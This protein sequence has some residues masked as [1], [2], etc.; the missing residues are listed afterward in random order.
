MATGGRGHTDVQLQEPP[1][2]AKWVYVLAR[3]RWKQPDPN[4]RR[5]KGSTPLAYVREFINDKRTEEIY[6]SEIDKTRRAVLKRGG[7]KLYG[8]YRLLVVFAFDSRHWMRGYLVDQ[9]GRPASPGTIAETMGLDTNDVAWAVRAL[10]GPEIGLLERVDYAAAWKR[11][12]LV[13]LLAERQGPPDQDPPPEGGDGRQA[14]TNDQTDAQAATNQQTRPQSGAGP[15]GD[16]AE[17]GGGVAATTNCNGND[18]ENA[19]AGA[20]NGACLAACGNGNM[21]GNGRNG[22]ERRTGDDNGHGVTADGDAGPERQDGRPPGHPNAAGRGRGPGRRPPAETGPGEAAGPEAKPASPDLPD[23]G[24]QPPAAGPG[25][26]GCGD[27]DRETPAETGPGEAAGSDAELAS[28]AR[29]DSTVWS[30]VHADR[31]YPCTWAE[32][33][34]DCTGLPFAR[35][36]YRALGFAAPRGKKAGQEARREMGTFRRAWR[37]VLN[38][39]L[40]E[41]ERLELCEVAIRKARALAGQVRQASSGGGGLRNRGAVWNTWWRNKLPKAIAASLAARQGGGDGK[42]SET[43]DLG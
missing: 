16:P 37:T 1:I 20:E 19:S 34:T 21:N 39:P 43:N 28:P 13:W 40:T 33:R 32:V 6:R 18:N 2:A 24:G 26:D 30:E 23:G 4:L 10:G 38:S 31:V 14:E 9:R 15:P 17:C 3:K 29:P 25:Q 35:V 11:E 42:G 27:R 12:Q 41:A 8:M 5:S 22:N 7:P 36:I